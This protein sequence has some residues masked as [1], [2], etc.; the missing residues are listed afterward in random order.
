M[1]AHATLTGKK[2]KADYYDSGT[3]E[4]FLVKGQVIDG[5]II[6]RLELLDLAQIEI[7]L[8]GKAIDFEPTKRWIG[9]RR[10]KDAAARVLIR[11]GTGV[12]RV[13]GKE[14]WDYFAKT[15]GNATNFLRGIIERE[16]VNVILSQ[17]EV[18]IHVHRSSPDHIQQA[19]AVAHALAHALWCYDGSLKQRLNKAGYGGV[20]IKKNDE[21]WG[22]LEIMGAC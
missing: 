8:H 6:D 7:E 17:M 18:I 21:F 10:Y 12:L 13:N 1:D 4:V 2:S 3:W 14:V 9:C 11:D 19:H 16:D 15:P 22:W 5:E 20:K